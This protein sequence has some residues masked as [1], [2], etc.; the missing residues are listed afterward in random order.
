MKKLF[1]LL[2]CCA[3]AAAPGYAQE[4]D[5]VAQVHYVDAEASFNNNSARGFYDCLEKLDKAEQALGAAN[6]KILA[7]K[8]E[9]YAKLAMKEGII[10]F[11]YLADSCLKKFIGLYNPNQFSAAR[12]EQMKNLGAELE[13]Y[14]T[15]IGP[16]YA[17]LYHANYTDVGDRYGLL[18]INT[19]KMKRPL[20][21]LPGLPSGR[22]EPLPI[23]ADTLH[24]LFEHGRKHYFALPFKTGAEPGYLF[25]WYAGDKLSS[26]YMAY[27]DI[28][29]QRKA[30]A[31]DQTDFFTGFNSNYVINATGK[32]K[33]SAVWPRLIVQKSAIKLEP[34]TEYFIW[35]SSS[36]EYTLKETAS[37]PI[38]YSLYVT[39]DPEKA[40]ESFF[41]RGLKEKTVRT[42]YNNG[43]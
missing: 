31:A 41:D 39:D 13:T 35:F 32:M 20:S 40:W 28:D 34:H 27:K 3:V 1:S 6:S 14:K 5:L 24:S 15:M 11:L 21:P 38:Y 9:A 30:T 10:S 8:T 42:K 19:H 25:W 43:D 22:K 2:L 18:Y 16:Q 29:R 26:W 7:L 33:R 23:V 4:Q 12:Y 37:V 17:P 36:D